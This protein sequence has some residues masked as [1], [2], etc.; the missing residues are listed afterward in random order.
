[1]LRH[2]GPRA[3]AVLHAGLDDVVQDG[4]INPNALDC[5]SSRLMLLGEAGE[6]VA[7]CDGGRVM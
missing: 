3:L 5:V 2:C 4:A 7:G 1:V 6:R